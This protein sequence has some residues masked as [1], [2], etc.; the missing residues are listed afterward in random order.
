M[1]SL[2]PGADIWKKKELVLWFPYTTCLTFL[3][4]YPFYPDKVL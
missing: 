3:S 4:S 1:S 2:L